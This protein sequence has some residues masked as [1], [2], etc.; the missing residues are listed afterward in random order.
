MSGRNGRKQAGPLFKPEELESADCCAGLGGRKGGCWQIRGGWWR[1]AVGEPVARQE[2]QV[3]VLLLGFAL[4]EQADKACKA[5]CI[6]F[7]FPAPQHNAL[8]VFREL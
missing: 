7:Q 5:T 1:L 8:S 2:D 3:R 6:E 4:S